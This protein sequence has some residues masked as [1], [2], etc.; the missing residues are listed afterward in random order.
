[1]ENKHDVYRGKDCMKNPLE[2]K[3]WRK[4]IL[5]K[6]KVLTNEQEKSYQNAKICYIFKEKSDDKHGKDK[7]YRKVRDHGR[8]AG[9]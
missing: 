7:N 3:L 2:K 9:E 1:M 6:M 4:L 8:Y 5:K